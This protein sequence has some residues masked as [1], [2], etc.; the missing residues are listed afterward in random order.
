LVDFVWLCG[1]VGW[2]YCCCFVGGFWL[3]GFVVGGCFV[4]FGICVYGVGV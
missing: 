2:D 1:V 3:G 4:G